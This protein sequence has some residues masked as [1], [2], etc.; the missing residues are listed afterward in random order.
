MRRNLLRRLKMRR[1]DSLRPNF[2]R[3]PDPST[4][5]NAMAGLLLP[6]LIVMMMAPGSHHGLAVDLPV[7]KGLR[8]QSGALREDALKVSVTRDGTIYFRSN[9][10]RA[11]D[12][13]D[14]IRSGW[15][16]GAER[17]VYL[18]VDGR[19]RYMDAAE[20]I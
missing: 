18:S 2:F 11:G 20:V 8:L 9:K 10:V 14:A 6:V 3:G 1:I 19:S 12:L 16:K 4:L 17:K 15:E 13:G 7:A 5:A